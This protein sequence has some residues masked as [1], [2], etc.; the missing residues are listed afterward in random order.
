MT[1]V[2]KNVR[3]NVEG[4]TLTIT[5]DLSKN[6]G[7]SGSGKSVIIASTEGNQPVPGRS[8]IKVGLNIY[9]PAK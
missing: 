4:N 1:E 8:E 9:T 2:G 7:L 5:I 3:M 6:F